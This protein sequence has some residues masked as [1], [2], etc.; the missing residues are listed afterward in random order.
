MKRCA[1]SFLAAGAAAAIAVLG[2]VATTASAGISGPCSA[3]IAG[4]GVA[5]AGTGATSKAITVGH[6]TSVPVVMTASGALSHV[7]IVMEFAGFSWVVRDKAV[8]TSVY[9]DTVPVQSYAKYGVGL[10]KVQGQATG[11]GFSCTG[12]AL[13]KVEGSPYTSIA[14]GVGIGAAALGALGL[15]GGMFGGSGAIR[16]FRIVRGS[17]AGLIGGF[18][19]LL[20]LQQAAILYPTALVA[21]VGLALGFG[22]GTAAPWLGQLIGHGAGKAAGMTTG[23]TGGLTPHH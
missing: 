23:H 14:G 11:A 7:R 5:N 12:S 1:R 13:V 10:Y 4:V 18:G 21:A 3:S 19:V 16:P 6:D 15:V 22:L 8:T 20:L 17:L 9:R 2:L